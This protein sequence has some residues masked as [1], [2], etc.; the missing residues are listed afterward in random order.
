M[1][2]MIASTAVALVALTGAASAMSSQLASTVQTKLD[3][4]GFEVSATSLSTPQLAA[5]HSIDVGSDEGEGTI[6]AQIFAV[7]N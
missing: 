4:Y 2:K 1:K 7:L 6:R 5:I 3:N